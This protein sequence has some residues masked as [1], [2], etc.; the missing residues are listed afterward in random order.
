MWEAEK[1]YKKKEKKEKKLQNLETHPL[2]T[3]GKRK[4]TLYSNKKFF[5][6]YE[7][8]RT[9]HK[10][11]IIHVLRKTHFFIYFKIFPSVRRVKFHN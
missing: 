6:T 7:N 9:F 2:A 5:V 1:N 8:L 11:I 10:I 3:T 4:E